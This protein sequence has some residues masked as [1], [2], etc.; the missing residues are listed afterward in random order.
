MSSLLHIGDDN[1]ENK[2]DEEQSVSRLCISRW[3]KKSIKYLKLSEKLEF[4]VNGWKK[5]LQFVFS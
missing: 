4:V 5:K 2:T 3:A 1:Y